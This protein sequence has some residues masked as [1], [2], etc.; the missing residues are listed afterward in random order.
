MKPKIEEIL[1]ESNSITD[2]IP[3]FR[4]PYTKGIISKYVQMD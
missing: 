4:V 2:Y 1:K 3:L